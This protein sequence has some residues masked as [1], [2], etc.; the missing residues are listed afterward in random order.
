MKN[1]RRKNDLETKKASADYNFGNDLAVNIHF[2]PY[3]DTVRNFSNFY[4]KF[5]MLTAR[6]HLTSTFGVGF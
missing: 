1:L 6:N 4:T 2:E 5:F 3:Q